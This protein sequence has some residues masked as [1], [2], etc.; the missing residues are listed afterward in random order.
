MKRATILFFLTL[1]ATA[2][3]KK[4]PLIYPEMLVPAAPANVTLQQSGTSMKLAFELPSKDRAGR[5]LT[6]LAGVTILKRDTVADQAA[7]CSSCTD[8]YFLFKKLNLDLLP[9]GTQRR[10]SLLLVLDGDVHQGRKYSYIVSSFTKEDAAG[11]AS[12]PVTAAVVQPPLPPVVQVASQPTEI[13][14]EF[15]GLPPHDGVFV[16]YNVYR[17]LKGERFSYWPL[18]REPFTA[19]RFSDA[20]LE[21]KTSY[22]YVVRT[23]ARLAN[24]S[25]IESGVSNEVEAKLKDDE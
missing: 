12:A 2:C 16:G 23:V 3:G 19:N 1:S 17:A 11:A 14:L 9:T 22:V 15:V 7:V 24:G 25:F 20:G 8:D 6:N 13:D 5:S 10:G 18:N 4:G 21:R